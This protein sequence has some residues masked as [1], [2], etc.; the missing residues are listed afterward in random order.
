MSLSDTLAFFSHRPCGQCR[1]SCLFAFFQ[2]A[3]LGAVFWKNF[4]LFSG[5][6]HFLGK[7]LFLSYTLFVNI[8]VIIVIFH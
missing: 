3:T 5:E 4:C 1:A 2:E 7:T 6:Y 8:M